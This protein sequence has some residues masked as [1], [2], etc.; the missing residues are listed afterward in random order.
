MRRS[1]A[2]LV[3]SAALILLAVSA[4]PSRADPAPAF[5]PIGQPLPAAS[6]L[7]ARPRRTGMLIGGLVTLGASYGLTVLIVLSSLH[8]YNAP[9]CT[10]PCT[11]PKENTEPR[12][13]L[14]PVVGPWIAMSPAPS[15][16][17]GIL[18]LLGLAQATGVAL[19]VGGIVRYSADGTPPDDDVDVSRA[20][21]AQ[22]RP[23]RIVTFGVLP[24]RDGAFGFLSGRM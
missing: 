9:N 3:A 19:T 12:D 8:S 21:R 20:R 24:T 6:P 14:I 5:Q 7:A 13:L 2:S 16:D 11:L 10:S 17:I 15:R 1:F 18:T 4:G 22:S 23:S